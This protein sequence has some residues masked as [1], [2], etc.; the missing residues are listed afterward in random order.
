MTLDEIAEAI[1]VD[2]HRRCFSVEDRL[3][4]PHNVL[5]I[6]SSMVTLSETRIRDRGT[7]GPPVPV[8]TKIEDGSRELRL[9]HYSV[10]EY[11]VSQRIRQS[12]MAIF[13]VNDSLAH[14]Y[15]AE[16][17]LIYLLHFDKPAAVYKGVWVDF[18][19]IDY[20]A[21]RWYEHYRSIPKAGQGLLD[22]VLS[23][24]NTT[25]DSRFINWL[26]IYNPD[27]YF[28]HRLLDNLQFIAPPLYYRFLQESIL[29]FQ[30]K[31]GIS[32]H[33][34]FGLYAALQLGPNECL[35]IGIVVRN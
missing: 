6:C 31:G 32:Y 4:D 16:V 17:C 15:M 23:L 10:K 35:N 26:K 13:Y 1:V 27:S 2:R 3:F 24:L 19:F 20:A 7:F 33:Q 14:E 28:G 25:R 5:E 29:Y 11:I 30:Y 12:P 8:T 18:P 21:R 22:L 9:A 34:L